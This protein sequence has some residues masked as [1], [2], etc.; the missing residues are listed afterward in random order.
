MEYALKNDIFKE[1]HF[2]NLTPEE[3]KGFQRYL[4]IE[5]M[6]SLGP[7]SNIQDLKEFFDRYQLDKEFLKESLTGQKKLIDILLKELD[8]G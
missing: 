8:R 7:A 6:N 5:Y 2:R 1:G 3:E 4:M